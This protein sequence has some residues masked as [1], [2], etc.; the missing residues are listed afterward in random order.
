MRLTTGAIASA[1]VTDRAARLLGSVDFRA[2]GTAFDVSDRITRDVGWVADRWLRE[3][4]AGRAFMAKL[5]NAPGAGNLAHTQL[6]NP[7]GSTITVIL[8][9]VWFS[10][11]AAGGIRI[12]HYNTALT[13]L[14]TT[15]RNMLSGGAAP[16]AEV[17]VQATAASIGSPFWES[18]IPAG[19][20]FHPNIEWI[21]ELGAGEGVILEEYF[22][23][24][25]VEGSFAWIEV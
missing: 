21:T 18:R 14:E 1:D 11:S 22:A 5:T 13:T 15:S 4:R 25:N 2:G 20:L 17:R 9:H 3:M 19:Q 23:S 8:Y 12:A 10:L 16:V 7:V 6:F 24:I